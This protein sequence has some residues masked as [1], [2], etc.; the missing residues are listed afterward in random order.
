[1]IDRWSTTPAKLVDQILLTTVGSPVWRARGFVGACV[2]AS[3][4]I[5]EQLQERG[6]AVEGEIG[7]ELSPEGDSA[8]RFIRFKPRE[9]I[10]SKLLN[11]VS[12]N[13]DLKDLF[14]H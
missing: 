9:G 6:L 4:E 8:G 10:V 3:T 14:R 2:S 7:L 12:V 11:R 5:I 1:M 13:M